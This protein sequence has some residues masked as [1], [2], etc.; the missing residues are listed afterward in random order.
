MLRCDRG[1]TGRR[2]SLRSFCPKGV[3]VQVP[4]VAPNGQVTEWH[5]SLSKKQSFVGSSPTL[6]TKLNNE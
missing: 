3:G 1:G 2:E 6:V 5:T 4:P